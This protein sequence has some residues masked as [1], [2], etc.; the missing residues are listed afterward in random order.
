VS[1]PGDPTVPVAYDP[2]ELRR[3]IA[4]CFSASE[5]RRLA[6]SLGVS[7]SIAWDR[8][9]QEAVR[10]LVRQFERYYG[11]ETLVAK[12]RELRPLVEWPEAQPAEPGSSPFERGG[13]PLSSPGALGAPSPAAAPPKEEPVLQDPLVP[14]ESAAPRA[15]APVPPPRLAAPVWPGVTGPPA[16]P[17]RARSVDPR[18]LIALTALA[19]LAAVIAF[20]AGRASTPAPASEA[21]DNATPT[22]PRATP[23]KRPDGPA[24]RAAAAM[25]RTLATIG[26]ICEVGAGTTNTTEIL[27][28]A[29][30]QCG[31][32]PLLPRPVILAP[33]S[34][35]P[36]PSATPDEPD[37][38]RAPRGGD[39]TP[40]G[41]PKVSGGSCIRACDATH[42]GCKAQC[43]SEPTQSSKYEGYQ[44][45]RSRCLSAQSRCRLGCN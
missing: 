43:G 25:S 28:R 8:G 10:D 2:V 27:A 12:L 22:S 1:E 11:L 7:G 30:E 44:L 40:N 31:P 23:S 4:V 45:C 38:S 35:S 29:Y 42:I 5:L 9:T 37:R 6:E 20:A 26:R 41:L 21:A 19:V 34:P 17:G 39:A 33:P 14:S 16:A 13:P 18:V 3:R 36:P 24:T 15:F 32:A